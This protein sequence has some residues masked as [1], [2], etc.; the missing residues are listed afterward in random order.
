M[1]WQIELEGDIAL[2]RELSL[3]I[4]SP[5]LQ[6]V[7]E[8]E[9]FYL[10]SNQLETQMSYN[11][12]GALSEVILGALN[13]VIRL[14]TQKMNPVI[15]RGFHKV[16]DDGKKEVTAWVMGDG[17][18]GSASIVV[19]VYDADGKLVQAQPPADPKPIWM[20]LALSDT[21]VSKALR[22]FG[23]TRND[24]DWVSLYRIY[25]VVKKDVGT[26]LMYD[27][28]W[29]TEAAITNFTRTANH[30]DAAG[31]DARHGATN[32][33]PPPNPMALSEARALIE[34]LLHRWLD[35]KAHSTPHD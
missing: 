19:Q 17:I 27:K 30:P 31:D 11:E 9:R 15:S 12:I 21:T 32:D 25:E 35:H 33:Q 14:T 5:Q 28:G 2:L 20:T 16:R 3:T 7:Q 26:Q 22:L 4:A 18:F 24:H 10:E 1:F 23:K 8:G 13:G 6:I 34:L 29:A